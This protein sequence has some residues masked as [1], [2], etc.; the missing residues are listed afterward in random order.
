M[1]IVL[2]AQEV[3]ELIVEHL[4]AQGKIEDKETDVTWCLGRRSED[5]FIVVSQ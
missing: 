5:S 1:K 3:G 4:V 2:T